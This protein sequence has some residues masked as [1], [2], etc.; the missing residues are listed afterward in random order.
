MSVIEQL[1]LLSPIY[2][3]LILSAVLFSS[4]RSYTRAKV[5]LAVAMLNVSFVFLGNYLY[6][7]HQFRLYSILHSIHIFSVLAVYPSVFIYVKLLT[8]PGYRLRNALKHF[9]PS[10]LF[11]LLSA[12]GVYLF[13]NPEQ[14][15][16][17][18]STYRV[19]PSYNNF[20]FRYLSIVRF[21]NIGAL[22]VQ[23]LI[24][25]LLIFKALAE[26]R[27]Q[28]GD[29]FSNTS[30][31]SLGWIRFFNLAIILSAFGSIFFYAINPVKLFGDERYL[32]VPLYLFAGVIWVLG[33]LGNN[34]KPV[35]A[36]RDIS[37]LAET[38]S[39]EALP[40]DDQL[41]RA[42]ID[43]MEREK[44]Y[45]NPDLKI[46]DVSRALHTNRTYISRL[47]NQVHG[48]NFNQFLNR[49]RIKHSKEMLHKGEK[50][51]EEVAQDSGFGSVSTLIRAY[52]EMEGMT[53]FQWKKL[54]DK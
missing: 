45:L 32:M 37:L 5:W 40:S 16:Y 41:N 7:T 54:Q 19:D 24:Y 20:V 53:P 50:K 8:T 38:A 13:L 51:L 30:R 4:S 49:Y 21:F 29:F 39:E 22:F 34:Q 17:F 43:Y 23:I 31:I 35:F 10:F 25:G 12:S 28:V 18:L 44:A 3:S 52:K 36:E 48:C 15:I 1:A 27:K 6:F 2:V 11:F 42:L 33:I 9:T 47:I 26:H 46:W 14:R